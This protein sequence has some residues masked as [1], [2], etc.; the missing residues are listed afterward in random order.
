VIEAEHDEPEDV[1]DD[2]MGAPSSSGSVDPDW[3]DAQFM[4]ESRS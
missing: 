3:I 2:T 1:E 4:E